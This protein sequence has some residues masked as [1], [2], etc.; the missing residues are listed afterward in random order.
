MASD[1][2]AGFA[3]LFR[4]VRYPGSE[5]R[6]F[7]PM[8][9]MPVPMLVSFFHAHTSMDGAGGLIGIC[10]AAGANTRHG[11]SFAAS[12][13]EEAKTEATRAAAAGAKKKAGIPAESAG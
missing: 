1:G 11:I 7:A 2:S 9:I 8:L 3:S 12:G 6:S 13:R 10:F 5:P 4:M